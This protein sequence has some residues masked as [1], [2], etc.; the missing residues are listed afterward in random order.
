MKKILGTALGIVTGITIYDY[1]SDG[2]ID[3]KKTIFVAIF[4]LI[5]LFAV[6]KMKK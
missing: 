2:A 1:L 6:E 4:A 3:W 5:L